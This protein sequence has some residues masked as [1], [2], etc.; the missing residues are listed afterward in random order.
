MSSKKLTVLLDGEISNEEREQI[1]AVLSSRSQVATQDGEVIVNELTEDEKEIM[2]GMGDISA[3]TETSKKKMSQEECDI[4]TEQ[5]KEKIGH[6]C[7]VVPFNT[8]EWADGQIVG[9]IN[10]K[11][12]RT[13]LFAI[14]LS[15]GRRIVK[16]YKSN[17]LKISEEKSEISRRAVTGRNS[18]SEKL[19]DEQLAKAV[20]EAKST[21]LGH[22]VTFVPFKSTEEER[23]LITG[24]IPDKR[25]SRVL[26]RIESEFIETKMDAD[27][28]ETSV[29]SKR[30][31]HKTITAQDIKVS[32]EVDSAFLE[33]YN[34]RVDSSKLNLTGEQ[35]VEATLLSFNKAVAELE[36]WT[37]IAQTREAEYKEAVAKFKAETDS[38][39]EDN[40]LA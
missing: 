23:G 1:T 2:E 29:V 20:E 31:T 6:M 35:L 16:N 28:N 37:R 19:S 34:K 33:R 17:M 22:I 40:D 27:G 10:D 8:L 15:D 25:S 38:V 3:D 18:V 39:T 36:K 12:A 21:M 13:P 14:R 32:D 26:V 24:I 30:I 9:V 4:L 7:K 11:R 5:L